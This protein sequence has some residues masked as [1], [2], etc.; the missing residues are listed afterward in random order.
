MTRL[1]VS[2]QYA[3]LTDK[4]INVA[5]PQY[6]TAPPPPQPLFVGPP[7]VQVTVEG[8]QPQSRVTVLFRLL[9]AI[10][11]FIV[12]FF[13]EIGALVVAFLGWWGALFMGQLPDF[14]TS[15]L[16][17][18]IR[19]MARVYAYMF[20][21]TDEYPPFTLDDVPDYPV[22]I[23]T[24]RERLNRA[25]VFFRFILVIP[26]YLL[27]AILT[28]GA[29]T[30]VLFITWLIAL[31]TGKVPTSLHLAYSAVLRFEIRLFC[32]W[33]LVTPTYPGG[34]FGDGDFPG[35][36]L[37]GM[38]P[39]PGAPGD[40]PAPGGYPAPSAPG[41]PPQGYPAEGG[42]PAQGG[43]PPQGGYDAPGYGT[44]AGPGYGPPAETG[45]DTPSGPGY[46]A[47]GGYGTP[48]APGGYPAAGGYGYGAQPG[49]G[50]GEAGYGSPG[51]G[52]GA[53]GGYGPPPGGY[54][55]P[56]Y[57]PPPAA[58]DP[59]GWRLFLT[60]AAKRLVILFIVLGVLSY[61]GQVVAQGSVF[62]SGFSGIDNAATAANANRSMQT[63]SDKL[64]SGVSKFEAASKSCGSNLGCLQSADAEVAGTFRD[65]ANAVQTTPMP[66]NATA[67]ANTLYS[68]TLKLASDY[69]QLSHATSASQY[70]ALATGNLQRDS[71]QFQ[72]DA[73]ALQ[74]ALNKDV[75][76][77]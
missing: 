3:A 32:Y 46:A 24:T 36:A 16:T 55:Q 5:Y 52:Y 51:S 28:Y 34:L 72:T 43:Y 57:G 25:A 63:A 14:A 35:M 59:I 69:T 19:W 45:Y 39:A 76:A 22:R 8:A 20:L 71:S 18:V 48:G 40:Y 29:G 30:I 7:P 70:E 9:M 77:S 50:Y 62:G 44:P 66:S 4:R 1:P 37:R 21:L 23:A 42:Y 12:L 65:F 60:P 38:P 17:G 2:R 68:G 53:P 47:P 26:V 64:D 58:D 10:P 74:S 11:H 27:N 49:P 61:F 41:Y 13:L 15:Y 33:W 73:D 75:G 54:A 31:V 67:P 56:G 6:P